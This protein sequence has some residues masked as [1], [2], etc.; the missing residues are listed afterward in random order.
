MRGLTQYISDLRACRVRELEEKRINREMAHIRQKFKEGNLDGYQKKKYLAKVVFTYILGYKVDVGHMEAVNLVSSNKYSEK[1]IGY[2]AVTLLM[3]E[4]SELI[5]LVINSIRKDLDDNNEVN[6]CL[7]LNA[8]ANIGGKE[9]AEALSEDVHRLLVSATS[10]TFVKKKAALTLLRFYRKHP[11]VLPVE[12]WADRLVRLMDDR[13]PGVVLTVTTLVMA[14]AHDHLDAYA[15]CYQKGVDRLTRLVFDRDFPADYVYY[16]VPIPWLQVKLL[17]MLQYYPPPE[18]K[19]ILKV[20]NNTL[21]TIVNNSQE[22]PKN[23]Q[24][25]NAQNA[26]LFEAINLAIHLDPES[27]IVQNAAKLLGKFILAKETNVRYLGLDVMAHLA[28]VSE[29]L[30]PIKKHQDT[31]IL[32][33][34]DRDISVRR[35]GLD[36]LYSMCDTSNAKTIVGELLKYLQVADYNLR[37]EMVLKIAILTERFAI[38]YE[39]YVDTILQLISTAGDH[40]GPEVWYRVV[41]LVTNNEDLQAYAA[42]A[43]YRHLR[44]PVCHENMIKV[45][46]YILGEFG[47]LIANDEGCSPIEQFQAVHSK[48]NT[49]SAATRALLLTTYIKWVNLF[50]EIKDQLVTIFDRYRHVLDAELQQRACEYLAIATRQ[51]D[52]ELL[53]VMCEEMPPFPERESALLTRLHG[54]S[55]GNHDK[56]TWVIGGKSDN[57]ERQASRYRSFTQSSASGPPAAALGHV[58]GNGQRSE[59]K[60]TE[61]ETEEPE[62]VENLMGADDD[63]AV[64]SDI[65]SSLAGLNIGDPATALQAPLLGANNDIQSPLERTDIAIAPTAEPIPTSAALAAMSL[66]KGHGIEKWLERLIYNNEG[67]LYEDEQVQIGLKAEYHGHLGR[68]ALYIGNKVPQPFT[69]F[70][71][72]IETLEP[73]ALEVKFH[74]EPANEIAG[75][76]QVQHL[77]S[78][79]CKRPYTSLPIIKIS[80]IA[81]TVR[82]LALRLPVFLSKFVEPIEL[83][84]VAFFERWKVIGGPPREAQKIF[85]I[86]LLRNGDVDI[87]RNS[88]VVDGQKFAVLGAIDPNPL[89]PN[90]DAS[91]ARLTIRSTN[92]MVSAEILEVVAKPLNK[93]TMAPAT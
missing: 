90:K 9:M 47:H 69:S 64:S 14:I 48:I 52:N 30:S 4:N 36:L 85:P 22:T 61:E 15:M 41:Q 70:S 88:K 3:H 59:S 49:C 38:E 89:N 86:E 75:L 35:R 8:I 45:G 87:A 28:A 25:N 50:P 43:V 13:N 29:S 32:S 81:G 21:N 42:K 24:H 12:E 56:R 82:T 16:K 51:D 71:A 5:R 77:L 19:K 66:T 55:E 58:N 93:D 79:D 92:D 33:L 26:I 62:Q 34:K 53:E 78:I 65:L 68:I 40:V 39:W 83:T 91:L 17:R 18:N 57:Q 23:V 1:Q 11:T 76:T 10:T 37:E 2:L 84:S 74:K 67:V 63:V 80:F 73:G 20:L 54:K 46:G 27:Q 31:I 60:H 72:S 6:N 7:A 44:V